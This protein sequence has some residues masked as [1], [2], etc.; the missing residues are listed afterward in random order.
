MQAQVS[1]MKRELFLDFSLFFFSFNLF[2]STI[3]FSTFVSTQAYKN[4]I[5]TALGW[6]CCVFIHTD[7]C[8]CFVSQVIDWLKLDHLWDNFSKT[9][10]RTEKSSLH[11][12]LTTI[13]LPKQPKKADVIYIIV[14][15]ITGI[16]LSFSVSLSLSL[17]YIWYIYSHKI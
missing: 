12:P 13:N 4:Y 10:G 5:N 2:A 8:G 16:S 14:C 15:Y 1:K 3:Y 9:W 17:M 11:P 6:L 7:V